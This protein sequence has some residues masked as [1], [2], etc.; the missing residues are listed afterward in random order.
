MHNAGVCFTA[1]KTY[2]T[3]KPIYTESSLMDMKLV[4]D[5]GEPHIIGSW[6]RNFSIVDIQEV[7]HA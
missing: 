4:N 1:G 5:M 7:Q 3:S 2:E 6:W